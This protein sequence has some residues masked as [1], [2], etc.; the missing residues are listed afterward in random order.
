MKCVTVMIICLYCHWENNGVTNVISPI[1][2]YSYTN[3]SEEKN[4][5]ACTRLQL[6][7]KHVGIVPALTWNCLF[8][9]FAGPPA[10]LLS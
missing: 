4:I 2:I 8:T 10:I 3:R 9:E 5:T 6:V 7:P 1:R